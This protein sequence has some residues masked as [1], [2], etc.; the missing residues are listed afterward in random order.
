MVNLVDALRVAPSDLKGLGQR[1][2]QILRGAN[3]PGNT[4]NIVEFQ[5]RQ[6]QLQKKIDNYRNSGCGD[7]PAD[8]TAWANMPAASPWVPASLRNFSLPPW[9][10][11][12]AI[13]TGGASCA[14]FVPGCLEIEG[15]LVLAP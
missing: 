14:I 6:R 2:A 4:N 10:V 13:I 12:A 8:I 11:P 9:V 5:N 1:F 3:N 15:G 7:P